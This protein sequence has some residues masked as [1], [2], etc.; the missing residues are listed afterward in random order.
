MRLSRP[1]VVELLDARSTAI[2]ADLMEPLAHFLHVARELVQQD[3]DKVLLMMI[4]IVRSNLHPDFRKLDP[5]DIRAGRVRRLP[6][7]GI[8]LRSLAESTGIPRETV[9]RKVQDLIEAGWVERQ[10]SHLAYTLKAYEAAGPARQALLRLAARTYE[11]VAQV[12]EEDAD[13][14]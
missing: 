11:V 4:I 6:S 5:A 10:G 1:Q 14:A 8:N 13:P 3:A 2:A 9:R 7:L 12:I